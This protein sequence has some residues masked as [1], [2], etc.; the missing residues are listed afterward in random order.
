MTIHLQLFTFVVVFFLGMASGWGFC[1]K[2]DWVTDTYL[3]E[4]SRWTNLL[5]GEQASKYSKRQHGVARHGTNC[6]EST[7]AGIGGK[8]LQGIDDQLCIGRKE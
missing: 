4:R 7:S 1:S 2:V 5:V 3:V 8:A 6:T